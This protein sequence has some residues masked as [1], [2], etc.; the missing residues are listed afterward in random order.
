MILVGSLDLNLVGNDDFAHPQS[1]KPLKLVCRA[2]S[3]CRTY[4]HFP[5]FWELQISHK[6][7]GHM[8]VFEKRQQKQGDT[9]ILPLANF[10]RGSRWPK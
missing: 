1:S 4:A 10:H 9:L 8:H 3:S 6:S 2:Q 5:I 7:Q